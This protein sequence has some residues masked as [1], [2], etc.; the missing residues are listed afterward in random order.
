M[1][2]KLCVISQTTT[3][4]TPCTFFI[5]VNSSNFLVTILFML[6]VIRRRIETKDF[7]HKNEKEASDWLVNLF[8]E[9]V[10]NGQSC[11]FLE[12]A[13]YCAP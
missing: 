7:S 4:S 3:T 8:R 10:K 13:Q 12:V 6:L 2:G 5:R 1:F 9:K 11:M